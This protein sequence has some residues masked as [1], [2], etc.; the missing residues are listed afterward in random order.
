MFLIF[1]RTFKYINITKK[2]LEL[3]KI[4]KQYEPRKIAL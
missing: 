4:Y 3:N 2:L 1:I